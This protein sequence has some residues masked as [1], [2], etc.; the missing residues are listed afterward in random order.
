MARPPRPSLPPPPSPPPNLRRSAC[1]R[2]ARQEGDGSAVE[3][4]LSALHRALHHAD[5]ESWSREAALQRRVTQLEAQLERALAAGAAAAAAATAEA[6]AEA[7]AAAADASASPAPSPPPEPLSHRRRSSIDCARR[8]ARGAPF[9][10]LT[11]ASLSP[12][13]PLALFAA[14]A[15]LCCLLSSPFCAPPAHLAPSSPHM[16]RVP[17]STLRQERG[18]LGK[19]LLTGLE[20]L[21][22]G[23]GSPRVSQAPPACAAAGAKAPF[24]LL[25]CNDDACDVLLPTGPGCEIRNEQKARTLVQLTWLARPRTALLLKKP[26]DEAAER[27]LVNI[28]TFLAAEGLAVLVE[29]AVHAA[30]GG[31]RGAAQTWLPADAPALASRVDF[32]VCLGGDGTILFAASLFPG[33]VPPI[34]SCVRGRALPRGCGG[35]APDWLTPSPNV[36]LPFPHP[37]CLQLRDGLPGLPHPLRALRRLPLP[38]LAAGG[39]GDAHHAPAPGLLRRPRRRGRK[40]RRG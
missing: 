11:Q 33:A 19:P 28:A 30:T 38:A 27:A 16:R 15:R 34:I 25:M 12:P 13:P 35:G 23:V 10:R 2:P 4:A 26:C 8:A 40:R 22:A 24:R 17:S 1:A 39:R 9:A 32:C 18:E 14:S 36:P 20:G 31:A 37:L 21:A 5:A 6:T 29:P 3:S 7:T